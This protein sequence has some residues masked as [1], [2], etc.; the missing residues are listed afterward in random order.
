VERRRSSSLLVRLLVAYLLPTLALFALFGWMAHGEAQRNLEDSLGRRLTGIAQAAATQI[1]PEAVLF[2]GPGD[3]GSRTAAR[4]RHKL[5]QLK[6]QTRVARIYILDRELRSRSDTRSGVRIGDRHYQAEADR[7]E[8]RQVFDRAEAASSVLFVG[9]D[10]RTYKTG[11]APVLKDRTVVAAVG[12]EGSAEFYTALARLRRVLLV[13]G[14]GVALLVMLVSV[15]VARRITRPLRV[16][17]RE[18]TRIGTGDLE[19]PIEA[20]SR[21]EV[22]LLARTMN[23]MREGLFERDTQMQMMLSGIAHEVRNPLGGIELFSGLLKEEL[24]EPA[25]AD[26]L[27][28]VARIEREL[29]YL[30]KVVGDFLDYARRAKPAPTPVD[31]AALQIELAEL[32]RKDADERGVELLT[33]TDAAVW[34]HC[35]ADQIR[36]V[37][38]NLTRNAIQAS[39]SGGR[40]L[41]RCGTD[42]Q[43]VFCEVTDRGAGIAEEARDRIFAPFYTT[44]E[45]GTGLGLAFAKKIVDEHGGKLTVESEP[46]Q[47]ATFRVTLPP[48]A[49]QGPS[50]GDDSDHR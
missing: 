14:A 46:G 7:P 31:L 22:G 23:E 15:V 28:H 47:G 13:T 1:R 18:A 37:L 20:T 6:Q 17:A 44:R 50:N 32:L 34:A 4:L 33:E 40:V 16:L 48:A 41:L 19:R 30:K 3:D 29:G 43:A 36:R 5:L 39:S 38:I 24:Q 45:K 21:D 9:A 26:K 8:L 27:E 10:G 25:D 12:V 42:D 49:T 35:D 11:Y 2:L